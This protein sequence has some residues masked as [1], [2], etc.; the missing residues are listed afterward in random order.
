[1]ECA[2]RA[3][4]SGGGGGGHGNLSISDIS[5]FRNEITKRK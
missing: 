3:N 1:M 5:N 2:K 4:G